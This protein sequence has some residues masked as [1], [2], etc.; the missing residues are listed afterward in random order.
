MELFGGT[1]ATAAAAGIRA[2]GQREVVI[3]VRRGDD[4]QPEQGGQR[5]ARRWQDWRACLHCTR[6]HTRAM[7]AGPAA[8]AVHGSCSSVEYR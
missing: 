5:D 6:S 3:M 4:A 8:A 1:L 7:L 2:R